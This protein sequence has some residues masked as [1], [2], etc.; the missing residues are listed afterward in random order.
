[1]IPAVCHIGQHVLIDIPGKIGR[2][3]DWL[4]PKSRGL[5]EFLLFP[6]IAW[7]TSEDIQLRGSY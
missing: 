1:L 4:A 5:G 2:L 6:L 3:G 7:T